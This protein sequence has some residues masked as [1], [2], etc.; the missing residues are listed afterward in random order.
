M[1]GDLVSACIFCAGLLLGV[2]LPPAPGV[3]VEVGAS[4]ATAAR[5]YQIE[6]GRDDLSDVT[7]KF[8]I[9]GLGVA[10]AAEGGLGA[11]TPPAEWRLRVALAPSHDEQ[12]QKPFSL[13]NTTASGTGRYE[14]LAIALRY[15]LDERNSLE[16]A[17]NRRKHR[18]TDL[19]DI[20][21]ERFFLSEQRQLS[22]ERI[23]V[24]VGWRH[25][26]PNLEA[27]VSGRYVRPAGSHATAG[28]FDLASGEIYG[29]GVEGRGRK[30][31][32]TFL[33]SAERTSGSI[34]VHEENRPQFV[35][36]EFRAPAT[37]EAYRAGIGYTWHGTELLLQA[38]YDR[39]RLPFV[40]FAVLGTEVAAL[41]SGFHPDSRTRVTLVD[42][43]ARH[44]VAEGFKAKIQLR[45]SHGNETLT[46][47][48]SAGV[49]P[50]RSLDIE[51]S[52]LFGAGSS[53]GPELSVTI[54]AEIAVP[55]RH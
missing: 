21:Q 24:G 12:E 51:R 13:Q 2:D 46:L 41:E 17:A 25:R 44:R 38:T 55:L 47:T 22:A 39:S 16:V 3:Q 31:R 33:A 48:D 1:G 32:W 19:L 4:Y 15:P 50:A 11:G 29:A 52:G 27:A 23:D 37:L 54:G 42:L 53:R 26:W 36:R 28:A 9:V 10:R 20:E 18:A 14:N 30:G 35:A 8:V 6:P 7:P 43:L 40:S 49:L 5:R 34:D 45:M